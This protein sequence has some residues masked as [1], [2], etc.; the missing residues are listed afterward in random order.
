M[1]GGFLLNPY[2]TQTITSND[3][4]VEYFKANST[5]SLL[6]N[7]SSASIT[8]TATLKHGVVSPFI[9]TRSGIFGNQVRT[10]LF[11]YFL[12]T[13]AESKE[14][15]EVCFFYPNKLREEGRNY[16]EST[17]VEQIIHEY[18]IQLEIYQKTYNTISSANE[19]VCPYPISCLT[20]LDKE[21]T[22]NDIIGKLDATDTANNIFIIKDTLGGDLAGDLAREADNA[23]MSLY[24]TITHTET[25]QPERGAQARQKIIQLGCI[26]MEFM[27]D[28]MTL[29]DYLKTHTHN[30][31]ATHRALSLAAYELL[32]AK[33]FGLTHGDLDYKNIM[34]NPNY[35][36][37][38]K[39]DN[40]D[41]YKGR[42]LLI[43][44]SKSEIEKE[45]QIEEEKAWVCSQYK[46]GLLNYYD[47]YMEGRIVYDSTKQWLLFFKKY[48]FIDIYERRLDSSLEFRKEMIQ[49]FR[50][51]MIPLF[52][53]FI[54]D[55]QKPLLE[56]SSSPSLI[57]LETIKETIND[58]IYP[59]VY[60]TPEFIG[61]DGEEFP[62]RFNELITDVLKKR[63]RLEPIRFLE[64]NANKVL[65][66]LKKIK[67]IKEINHLLPEQPQQPQTSIKRNADVLRYD[68]LRYDT[69]LVT[70]LESVLVRRKQRIEMRKPVFSDSE[71][72]CE[73]ELMKPNSKK[74]NSK[75]PKSSGG[76]LVNYDN[77]RFPH[78]LHVNQYNDRI[79]NTLK[80]KY[81]QR[82]K[83]KAKKSKRKKSKRTKSKRKKSKAKKSKRKKSKRTKSKRKKS[84]R[85][86]SKRKK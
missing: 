60:P 9:H 20:D 29:K 61:E 39:D 86:K 8:F 45:K 53:E 13:P 41:A 4:A 64:N 7:S 15:T 28:Y 69:G 1:K 3:E 74:P 36:Y 79:R 55:Y 26:I 81:R 33:R 37:I 50:K 57:K 49:K 43:D 34:Y 38:T 22:I 52:K 5:F 42:A 6:T 63:I 77:K 78:S 65:D 70:L 27:E 51:E 21:V 68:D 24:N 2:N 76:R 56:R 23:S 85:K 12:I 35:K 54:E 46:S 19:P 18:S 25:E 48:L 71:S 58:F 67:E 10:L 66:D 80:I 40:D 82:K 59:F 84:K 30:I 72:S 83:S 17:T 31:D 73:D 44:F 14:A 75:K 47:Q 16:I 11:K 62:D 32:R